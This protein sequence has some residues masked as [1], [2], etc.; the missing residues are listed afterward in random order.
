ME[1]RLHDLQLS[2]WPHI[3]Q[4]STSGEIGPAVNSFTLVGSD[5]NVS[6]SVNEYPLIAISISTSIDQ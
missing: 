4:I 5:F 2:K 3:G 1:G 6:N